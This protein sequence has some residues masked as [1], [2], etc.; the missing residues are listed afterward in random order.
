[1]A[2]LSVCQTASAA[3]KQTKREKRSKNTQETQSYHSQSHQRGHLQHLWFQIYRNEGRTRNHQ[4]IEIFVSVALKLE[5]CNCCVA[6][7]KV[8]LRISEASGE[9]SDANTDGKGWPI[10]IRFSHLSPGPAAADEV[11]PKKVKMLTLE[12][13]RKVAETYAFALLHRERVIIWREK[14]PRGGTLGTRRGFV[15]DGGSNKRL[16]SRGE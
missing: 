2:S 5:F 16:S 15:E 12:S 10:L 3:N 7:V 14:N 8:V 4:S 6:L 11:A 1:M 13:E 9:A